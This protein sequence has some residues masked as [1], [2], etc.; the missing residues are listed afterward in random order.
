[1]DNCATTTRW[2]PRP[3]IQKVGT[4]GGWRSFPVGTS[5]R[6]ARLL[7]VYPTRWGVFSMAEHEPCI[8]QSD[9][10]SRLGL[11]CARRLTGEEQCQQALEARSAPPT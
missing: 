1:M 8:G 9:D 5:H 11:R 4:A 7:G 6:V 2:R 3:V 10:L